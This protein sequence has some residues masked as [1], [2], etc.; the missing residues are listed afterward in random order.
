MSHS[1]L[2]K[3]PI[4]HLFYL[5]LALIVV[6][7]WVLWNRRLTSDQCCYL[8]LFVCFSVCSFVSFVIVPITRLCTAKYWLNP[9]KLP[10]TYFYPGWNLPFLFSLIPTLSHSLFHY[11]ITILPGTFNW[12][13]AIFAKKQ[14]SRTSFAAVLGEDCTRAKS[15]QRI[16]KCL[17]R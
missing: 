6:C 17:M 15:R 8:C 14:V 9:L 5:P 7:S 13:L 4:M 3:N 11:Q 1:L 12:Y 10:L 2:A 16:K